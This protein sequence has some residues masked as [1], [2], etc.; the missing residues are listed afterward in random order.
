MRNAVEI[1]RS[2][3]IDRYRRER[4]SYNSQLTPP[5]I[6]KYCPLDRESEQLLKMAFETYSLTA[7]SGLKIIKLARTIADLEQEEN[8]SAVHVAE[9]ISYNRFYAAKCGEKA[10]G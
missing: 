6:K 7:R 4:I 2:V 8:I 10:N 1:A 9:A 5:L 3:Q